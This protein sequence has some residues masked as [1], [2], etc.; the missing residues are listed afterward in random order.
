MLNRIHDLPSISI[1][2]PTLNSSKTIKNCLDSILMQDYPS[3]KIEIII[4]DGGSADNTISIVKDLSQSPNLRINLI[5]NKLRTGES[6]KAEGIKCTNNEILAFIDSDNVLPEPDWFRKMVEPFHNPS[7]VASEP[8]YYTYRR[9]DGYIT[10]YCSLIGMNDPICLFL[11]N[12]DRYCLLTNKWTEVAIE[13]IDKASYKEVRFLKNEMPTIGA[14]GFFIRRNKLLNY[15]IRDY[16]FDIDIIQFLY[17]IN[18]KIKIAKVKNGIIHIF[19]NNIFE[20]ISKQI[21]RFTDYTYYNSLGLRRYNWYAIPKKKFLKFIFY[22]LL[23]IPLFFQA[24]KGYLLKRDLAWFFHPIACWITL[25]VYS[26]LF[27]RNLFFPLKP[28]KR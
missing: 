28:K 17:S 16:F 13:Q 21:R 23:C 20:F 1:V 19:S 15:P 14:N 2:I 26:F 18:P 24:V 27:F 25:C 11:G 7:I 10:R 22:T 8:L 3:D 12:Y 9:E 6:G 4:A 5:Y